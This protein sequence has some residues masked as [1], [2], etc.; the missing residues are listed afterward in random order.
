MSIHDRNFCS[1]KF[2]PWEKF[3]G[4]HIRASANQWVENQIK[5]VSGIFVL[6]SFSSFPGLW[7]PD[8]LHTDQLIQ[9]CSL[10]NKCDS[11]VLPRIVF[12]NCLEKCIKSNNKLLFTVGNCDCWRNIWAVA[13]LDCSSAALCL[14]IKTAYSIPQIDEKENRK[15]VLVGSFLTWRSIVQMIT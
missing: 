10:P 6:L 14:F 8:I 11:T 5:W 12:C 3:L 7:S 13:V 9:Y 15:Q 4:K 2:V 1:L